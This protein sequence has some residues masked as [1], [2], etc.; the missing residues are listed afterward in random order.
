MGEPE[1]LVT[2]DGDV[3]SIVISAP[4][5]DEEAGMR[6]LRIVDGTSEIQRNRIGQEVVAGKEGSA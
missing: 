3:A 4:V 2:R 1:L 5:G 6:A